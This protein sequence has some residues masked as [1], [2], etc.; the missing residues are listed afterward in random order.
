MAFYLRHLDRVGFKDIDKDSGFEKS[1]GN[2]VTLSAFHACSKPRTL[3]APGVGS[4][5]THDELASP[6][7]VAQAVGIPSG[8]DARHRDGVHDG[9]GIDVVLEDAG[10]IQA[11]EPVPDHGQT[12]HGGCGDR[13]QHSP[14]RIVD[15]RSR[16]QRVAGRIV[17]L[18]RG[19]HGGKGH[20]GAQAYH[21]LRSRH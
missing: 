8:D 4:R 18:G 3:L 1:D 14:G 13:L 20:E 11:E 12:V 5:I 6:D 10:I 17:D 15:P 16:D 7:V 9:A 2:G 21:E 19:L